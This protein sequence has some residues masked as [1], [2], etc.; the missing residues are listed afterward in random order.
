MRPAS[1]APSSSCFPSCSPCVS[2]RSGCATSCP[3]P[4]SRRRSVGAS[5]PRRRTVHGPRATTLSLPR[6]R[7]GEQRWNHASP[8]RC[9]GRPRGPRRRSGRAASRG[10]HWGKGQASRRRH[11]SAPSE[12][13]GP[14]ACSA[15]SLIASW[16]TPRS[17]AAVWETR[18]TASNHCSKSPSSCAEAR[19]RYRW[20]GGHDG[21]RGRARPGPFDPQG[22]RTGSGPR[23]KLAPLLRFPPP[24]AEQPGWGHCPLRPG[25]N[26][27]GAR[28]W[29]HLCPRPPAARR[30]PDG[31][32]SGQMRTFGTEQTLCQRESRRKGGA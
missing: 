2:W 18:C 31:L 5:A 14:Y 28:P 26:S 7:C 29:P 8:L 1:R 3:I 13:R 15:S 9:Y 17:R 22:P 11:P 24:L 19:V 25:S 16:A 20:S 12:T 10:P 6:P 30:S 32:F 4:G 23:G 27:S 21:A